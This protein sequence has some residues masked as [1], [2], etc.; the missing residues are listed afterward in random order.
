MPSFCRNFL[1]R[2]LRPLHYLQRKNTK[3]HLRHKQQAAF[4]ASK[5]LLISAEVLVHFDVKKDLILSCDASPSGVGA[6]LAH[7]MPDGSERPVAY[8]SGSLNPAERNY[9]HLDKEGV[10][11]IFGV[12]KFHQYL[13]GRPFTITTDHKPLLGLFSEFRAVPQIASSRLQRCSLTFSA[14]Q[15][16]LVYRPDQANGNADG[17]SILPLPVSPSHTPEPQDYV[18]VMDHL[19]STAVNP[20]RIRLRTGRDPV[21]SQVRDYVMNDGHATVKIMTLSH[22]SHELMS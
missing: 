17:L 3:W 19:E 6:V 15:Y 8:A 20:D 13:Y 16:K 21:L 12:R 14:Y 5:K 7:R 2:L 4:E 18:F 10:A 9:S 1:Q 11:V 22:V